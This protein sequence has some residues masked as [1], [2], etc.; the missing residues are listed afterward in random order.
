MASPSRRPLRRSRTATRTFACWGGLAFG[1]A[2][3]A[4]VLGLDGLRFERTEDSLVEP[5]AGGTGGMGPGVSVGVGGELAELQDAWGFPTHFAPNAL[6]AAASLPPTLDAPPAGA[7]SSSSFYVYERDDGR[8]TSHRATNSARAVRESDWFAGFTAVVARPF[9]GELGVFGYVARSDGNAD[10]EGT[11][12]FVAPWDPWAASGSS[13]APPSLSGKQ[14]DADPGWTHVTLLLHGDAWRVVN[15][16]E[17]TGDFEL[18]LADPERMKE[19]GREKVRGQ[20]DSGW[21]SLL[22]YPTEEGGHGLL[23]YDAVTGRAEFNRFTEEGWALE[24]TATRQW[25]PRWQ[26][27][28]PFV[29][30]GTARLLF[31]DPVGAAEVADLSEDLVPPDTGATWPAN[32][33]SLTLFE[34]EG[35]SY[36]LLYSSETGAARNR[37]LH[38]F[39]RDPIVVR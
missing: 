32:M 10:L 27:L 16:N 18:F 7:V 22:A 37:L 33:T 23:K 12:S 36:A 2:G 26:L 35:A 39:E 6:I 1:L 14:G 25:T 4:D 5:G 21:S 20:W 17:N 19:S 34:V 13:A 11:W 31:Y 3:C 9:D 28:L 30:E 24:P 29:A 38:P 15:Y 8:F